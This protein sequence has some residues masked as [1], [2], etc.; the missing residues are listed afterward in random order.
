MEKRRV[1]HDIQKIFYLGP[2]FFKNEGF[3]KKPSSMSQIEL[4]LGLQARVLGITLK[5]SVFADELMKV[6]KHF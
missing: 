3:Y 6:E 4:W 2:F 5:H 1:V